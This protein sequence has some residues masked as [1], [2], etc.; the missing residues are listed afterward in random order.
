MHPDVEWH[1]AFELPDLPPGKTV[2][3]GHDEI[4]VLWDAFR[5]VWEEITIGLDEV[6]HE[7]GRLLL[8]RAHFHARG[9]SSGVE[10]DRRI[11]Y[12]MEIDDGM[13]ARLRPFDTE[14][15]VWAAAGLE[16]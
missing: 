3:R 14:T 1:V 15:E 11:F 7:E 4:R 6:L 16:P 10:L 2:Y 13:L 8:L 9:G 12:V 5:S